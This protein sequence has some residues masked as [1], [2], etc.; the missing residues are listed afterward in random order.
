MLSL[1]LTLYIF[2]NIYDYLTTKC[3]YIKSIWHWESLYC[4]LEVGK[5]EPIFVPLSTKISVLP[6]TKIKRS[7]DHTYSSFC[8]NLDSLNPR[9]KIKS[10]QEKLFRKNLK[11][12]G[13]WRCLFTK[14]F[15]FKLPMIKLL[16]LFLI[17]S[18]GWEYHREYHSDHFVLC[19]LYVQIQDYYKSFFKVIILQ[20]FIRNSC[21]RIY[22]V[23]LIG[24]PVFI[25][26]WF[27]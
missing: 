17:V 27:N 14:E 7:N 13:A 5:L 23:K 1:L 10:K 15:K 6:W 9:L 18:E 21:T 8:F 22:Y 4:K 25:K 2:P 16:T 19:Y 3:I 12:K 24:W 26:K 20:T 11:I